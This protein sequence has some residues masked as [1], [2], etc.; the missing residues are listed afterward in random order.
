MISSSHLLENEFK[1]LYKNIE[2]HFMISFGT[3]RDR[4]LDDSKEQGVI[5]MKFH[6]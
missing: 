5:K 4:G 6:S 3:E 2:S 1:W